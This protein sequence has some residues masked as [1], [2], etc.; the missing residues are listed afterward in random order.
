[1]VAPARTGQ[2]QGNRPAVLACLGRSCLAAREGLSRGSGSGV[3]DVGGGE[4]W[5]SIAMAQGYP[6]GMIDGY[7]LDAASIAVAG[8]HAVESGVSERVTFTT[9]DAGAV[10]GQGTYD[11]VTAFECIHDL[12]DPVAV[13][14]TMRSLV[15]PGGTVLVMDE[16]VADEFTGPSGGPVEQLMYGF[17]LFVC[18]PDSLSTPGSRATGTA[19]RAPVLRGYAEE[20]GFGDI[21]VLPVHL[22]I[23]RVTACAG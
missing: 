13:L 19:M 20:A 8:E 1:M 14:S 23:W 10:S 11:L 7:D 2:A 5:S 15:R 3:A 12:P 18:L 21:E 17:S 6:G 4:G 22:P 9:A 16:K